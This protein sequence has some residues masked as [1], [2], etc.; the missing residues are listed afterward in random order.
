MSGSFFIRRGN[1]FVFPE[2]EPPIMNIQYD[3][4]EFLAD[5]DYD[6]LCFLS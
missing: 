5:L 4:E 3:D 1:A 6:L 2:P